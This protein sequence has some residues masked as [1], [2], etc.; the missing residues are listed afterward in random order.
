MI[1]VARPGDVPRLVE[2][3]HQ[4]FGQSG[5]DAYVLRQFIDLFGSLFGVAIDGEAVVG[6][7]AGGRSVDTTAGWMLVLAVVPEARGRGIGRRLTDWLLDAL[8]AVGAR[9][10][11]LTVDPKNTGAVSLYRRAGFGEIGH[12]DDYF[13]PGE[14]RLVLGRVLRES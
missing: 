3:E 4:V 7:V 9:E 14:E 1:R 11:R 13:G 6:Y 10:C 2:I 12:E 5:Y 8:V